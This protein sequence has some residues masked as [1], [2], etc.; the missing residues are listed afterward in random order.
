[1]ELDTFTDKAILVKVKDNLRV[2]CKK[3]KIPK[4]QYL[5]II[6][7]NTNLEAVF[8]KVIK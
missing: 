8:D 7:D 5:D 1:M 4:K 2:V 6:Q 3:Q